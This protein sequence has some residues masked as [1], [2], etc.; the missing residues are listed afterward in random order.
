MKHKDKKQ[1]AVLL[2]SNVILIMIAVVTAGLYSRHVYKTQEETKKT[3]FIRTIES[4]KTISEN[5]LDDERGYAKD[6]ASYISKHNMTMS[7]ALSFLRTINTNKERFVHIVDMESYEAYSSYYPKGKEK[8]DTYSVMYKDADR[9]ADEVFGK[10]FKGIMQSMFD[11]TNE[12]FAVLGK[13]RLDE[14]GSMAVGVG[15][16]VTLVTEQGKK[17]YLLLRIIPTEVL[18]KSWVFPTEYSSAEVG[19]ITNS[20]D[21]VVQSSSMK[22]E[23]FIEYIR[24]YNFQEDYNEGTKLQ[25]QL[26]RTTDGTLKYKNFRGTDCVWYYSSFGEGSALDILGVIDAEDLKASIDTWYIVLVICGTLAVLVVIDGLYLVG[27]NH[28]LRESVKV[29]QEASKAKTQFLSAMSHDIRTPLNAVLGMMKIAQKNADDAEHVAECMEKGINSGKQL[30]T[31][32]NDVLDI[33]KI[34]SGKVVLNEDQVSLLDITRGMTE[35]LEQNVAQKG[36]EFICDFDSLP[37]KYVYADKMRLS[38]IYMNLLSNA[39]KYTEDGGKIWLRLYEEEVP[40]KPLSTKLIFYLKDTGIGMTEEFQKRMYTSFSREINTQVNTIQGTGLGL[41]IVKQMVDIME[42]M[43]ECK[44]APGKGTTFIVSMELPVVEVEKEEDSQ[45]EISQDIGDMHL[46]VAEDNELNWEIFREL[47]SEYQIICDRVENGKECVDRLIKEPAGTYDAI[48]M[49][50]NMPIMN[51][52]EAS[53]AIRKLEDKERN[54]IPIIAT[55][56][57]A[58]AEDVQACLEAGMNGHVSKPIDM[59]KLIAYLAKIKSKQ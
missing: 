31:L 51:G 30:L 8:I 41:S 6:W 12:D 34:E 38:Q 27:I 55:T 37:H 13:Y 40:E 50:V 44:S 4:M 46:L 1:K 24:G 29:A 10:T 42:G 33:S 48:L 47:I 21:Y 18:R 23:N 43:I 54:D 7:E 57:D 45:K 58:F 22:S 14:T 35:T 20:G 39:V 5:Y 3:A 49:D 9:R 19:I 59:D 53:R 36:I 17:A 32:I 56:A 15:N 25:D 2:I 52:Y 16:R 11:G 28:K 26:E